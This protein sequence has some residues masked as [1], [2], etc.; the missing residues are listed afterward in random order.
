M[1]ATVTLW[2][3]LDRP[4]R[5]EGAD[6]CAHLAAESSARQL[7]TG[8]GDSVVVIGDSWSIGHGLAT[9]ERS[10]PAQLRGRVSVFGFSGS[11]FSQSA[12]PCP[13]VSFAARVPPAALRARQV[14]FAGGL[15]DFDQPDAEIRAGFHAAVAGLARSHVVVVG[16]A[17]APR[18]VAGARAVDAILSQEAGLA[19]VRYVSTLDLTLPYLPDGLHLTAAGHRTFG[20]AVARRIVA[21]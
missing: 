16:P 3:A 18:R 9:P 10:W 13:G 17:K 6:R 14:V 12:S 20:E 11:G 21:R 5:A 8:A 2:I 1:A 15:N 19:G 7:V 4:G